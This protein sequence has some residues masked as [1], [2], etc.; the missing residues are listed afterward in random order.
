M[1]NHDS[2]VVKWDLFFWGGGDRTWC[3]SMAIS[4]HVSFLVHV[5]YEFDF[6]FDQIVFGW[7]KMMEKS[8][9]GWWNLNTA[10]VAPQSWCPLKWWRIEASWFLWYNYF[11]ERIRWCPLSEF[12]MVRLG[13]WNTILG[14][15]FRPTCAGI[16]ILW[17]L[18]E[19]SRVVDPIISPNILGTWNGGTHLYITVCKAYVREKPTQNSL[20][21]FSTSILKILG[22]WNVLMGVKIIF[23]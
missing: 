16:R 1:G 19:V 5:P 23:H 7:R 18:S 4:R 10:P 20:I 11:F 13:L 21:R 22:T 2:G 14:S 6:L 15:N 9:R 3:K 17:I 12:W 8:L